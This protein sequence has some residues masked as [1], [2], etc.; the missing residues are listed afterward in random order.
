[1]YGREIYDK[2]LPLDYEEDGVKVGG[3]IVSPKLTRPNRTYQT[4]FVNDRYVENYLI[5]ACVQGAYEPVLMKG[6]FPIYIIKLG[7]PF[8]RVDVNVHPNKKEVKF[9]NSSKIFGIVINIRDGPALS[10]LW[11]PP[12]KAN[13]AGIIIRLAMIAIAVSKISTCSVD[14]SMLT[15][16]LI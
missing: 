3:Y 15:S 1:M 13:T 7:I 4:L 14:S 2:L 10:V 8:D 11:S 6:R 16:F 12:E 9:D 5:S